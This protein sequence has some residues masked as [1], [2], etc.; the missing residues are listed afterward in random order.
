MCS[1]SLITTLHDSTGWTLQP[2]HDTAKL[3]DECY[4]NRITVV[5]DGTMPEV[6]KAL[7]ETGWV[8]VEPRSRVGVQYIT[9]SRRRVLRASLEHGSDLYPSGGH[10]QGSPLGLQIP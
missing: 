10:G 6:V 3:L 2:L 9:D 4:D 5:M 8:I 1:V 7:R